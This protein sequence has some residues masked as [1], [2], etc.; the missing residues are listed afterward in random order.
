MEENIA[1]TRAGVEYPEW[2]P[3]TADMG[4]DELTDQQREWFENYRQT[5]EE[6]HEAQELSVRPKMEG[7]RSRLA[8]LDEVQAMGEA[9]E[10]NLEAKKVIHF[11]SFDPH[12]SKGS[13]VYCSCGM[14]KLHKRGKVLAAWADKHFE[15]YGHYW[16]RS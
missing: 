2:L 16:K 7:I 6:A 14:F 10:K 9:A 13:G 3:E 12:G 15:K 8:L 5:L 11:M 1:A 4:W